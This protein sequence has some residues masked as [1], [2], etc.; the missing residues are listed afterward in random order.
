[1]TPSVLAI[2][3]SYQRRID[4]TAVVQL[5]RSAE[6]H[7]PLDDLERMRSMIENA[8]L[9]VSAW[10]GDRLVGLARTLT[11]FA[12][13]GFVA[14]LAVHP[15][16]RRRGIGTELLQRTFETGDGVEYVVRSARMPNGY[17]VKPRA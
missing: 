16:F 14:D 15:E 13:S 11:D 4:P 10:S 8:Q 12:F 17:W 7:G 1:M 6:L 9:V 5:F 2:S 3:Y